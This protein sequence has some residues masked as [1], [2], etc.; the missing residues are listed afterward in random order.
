MRNLMARKIVLLLSVLLA[1]LTILGA[2]APIDLGSAGPKNWAVLGLGGPTNVGITG[3]SSIRGM[4]PN[5]GVPATGSAQ[6]TGGSTIS[7][8]LYLNRAGEAQVNGQ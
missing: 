7:G 2:G 6:L 1:P 8:K 5:V 3:G 4:V